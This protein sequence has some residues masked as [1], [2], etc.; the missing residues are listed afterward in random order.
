MARAFYKPYGK[1]CAFVVPGCGLQYTI[2]KNMSNLNIDKSSDLMAK[3][4]N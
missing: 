1:G 3:V 4:Y 2:Y